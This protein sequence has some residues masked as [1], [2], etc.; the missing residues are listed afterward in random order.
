MYIIIFF[1]L[2]VALLASMSIRPVEGF[3][4]NTQFRHAKLNELG[5]VDYVDTMPPPWRGENGCFR[6]PCPSTFDQDIACW[7]CPW[8][9]SMPQNE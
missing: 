7:I 1:V 4:T 2:I 3:I 5:G 9:Y 6:H 8:V